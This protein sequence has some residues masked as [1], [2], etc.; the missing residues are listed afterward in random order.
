MTNHRYRTLLPTLILSG[1]ASFTP[2]SQ[3]QDTDHASHHE[4]AAAPSTTAASPWVEGEIRRLDT[5]NRKITLRHG[6]IPNLDMPPMTMVFKLGPEVDVGTL[7][8][9]ASVRFSAE[10]INGE[11]TL[12]RIEPRP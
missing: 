8:A 7:A 3:A 2:T 11:Y 10:L 6:D 1:I 12:T 9:G 4:T 5:P